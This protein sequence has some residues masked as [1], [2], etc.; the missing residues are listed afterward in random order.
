MIRFT[1]LLFLSVLCCVFYLAIYNSHSVRLH[2]T[3][4]LAYDLPLIALMAISTVIGAIIMFVI[5]FIRDTKNYIQSKLAQKKRK[6][7][8]MSQGAVETT[9]KI[10][11]FETNNNL[12]MCKKHEIFEQQ[13]RWDELIRLQKTIIKN[14]PDNDSQKE[15]QQ[16]ILHGYEYEYGRQ[17]LENSEIEK[18]G[19]IFKDVIKY[20]KS[21]IPAHLGLAEVFL[22]EGNTEA[23][24]NY[25][26]KVHKETNSLI[27][28]AR[29]EDL[30]I[31]ESEPSRLI[32]IYKN[33]LSDRPDADAIKLFLGK[34]YY[35]LEMLDEALDIF[36]SFDGTST[37]SE[38][39]KIKG[40]LHLRRNDCEK[41]AAEFLKVIGLK[42]ALRI[43]YHCL[44][45][46]HE[47]SDWEGRCPSCKTWNTYDF[48]FD[49]HQK[50]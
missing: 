40:S 32:R 1:S 24:I 11:A 50:P 15:A 45:C 28:L 21:F 16:R 49:K 48:N 43:P 4:E 12:V 31:N 10:P 7:E 30:L 44:N 26:E 6:K 39:H 46:N 23:G 36:N 37:Y 18:A 3:K 2:I 17:S 41:A 13:S 20:D 35:R 19:K 22:L 25:L 33:A 29:L 27:I 47:T 9:D 14:L 38:V 42:R 5:F 34:L 8:E